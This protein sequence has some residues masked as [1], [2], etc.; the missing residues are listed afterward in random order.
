MHGPQ[1]ARGS[2]GLNATHPGLVSKSSILLDDYL[3]Y[4]VGGAAGLLL[5][6]IVTL[7]YACAKKRKQ[8]PDKAMAQQMEDLLS[9]VAALEKVVALEQEV[10]KEETVTLDFSIPGMGASKRKK[11]QRKRSMMV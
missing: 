2:P 4:V 5:L 6:N 1:G 8:K 11:I 9:K 7:M 3:Y 10:K